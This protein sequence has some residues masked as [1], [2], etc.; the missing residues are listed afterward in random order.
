MTTIAQVL[1]PLTATCSFMMTPRNDKFRY[2]GQ[3]CIDVYADAKSYAWDANPFTILEAAG[4]DYKT[5]KPLVVVSGMGQKISERHVFGLD[6]DLP[7]ARLADEPIFQW[8][9]RVMLLPQARGVSVVI[10]ADHLTQ[11]QVQHLFNTL[12]KPKYQ[13]DTTA[14]CVS[15]F[16]TPTPDTPA[17]LAARQKFAAPTIATPPAA[18]DHPNVAP[19][20][21]CKP[22][23][24]IVSQA[25]S[26][27]VE[28]AALTTKN[29]K[30][31]YLA[32]LGIKAPNIKVDHLAVLYTALLARKNSEV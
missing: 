3:L 7:F 9:D 18:I 13:A 21:A 30:A 26:Q 27:A 5:M 31:M 4:V 8:L 16:R 29:Y 11:E 23:K 24:P 12:A 10:P 28:P 15:M 2:D 1:A 14:K 32:N 17:E 6:S 25:D 20:I 19:L 22:D